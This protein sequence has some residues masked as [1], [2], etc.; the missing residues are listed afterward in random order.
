M[1]IIFPTSE[2]IDVFVGHCFSYDTWSSRDKDMTLPKTNL[3]F[4]AAYML[5]GFIRRLRLKSFSL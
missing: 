1:V 2:E 5:Y 4:R 3:D